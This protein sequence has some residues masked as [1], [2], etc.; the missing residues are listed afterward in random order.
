V[1]TIAP[2][3][4]RDQ[5]GQ[6]GADEPTV[7]P[8]IEGAQDR[9]KEGSQVTRECVGHKRGSLRGTGRCGTMV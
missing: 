9:S 2:L 8:L 4:D 3:N 7:E 5:G 1:G 6:E